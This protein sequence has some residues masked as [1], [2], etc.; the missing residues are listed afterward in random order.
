MLLVLAILGILFAV[1]LSTFAQ[2]SRQ[3]LVRQAAVQIQA[4]LEQLRSSAIRYNRNFE[5]RWSASDLNGYSID[6]NDPATAGNIINRDRV[7]PQ[8][9][10]LD[11]TG[12]AP[13]PAS[14]SIEYSSPLAVLEATPPV[15]RVRIAN[16][17]ITNPLF[18][19]IV[20]V[21]GR[22]AISATN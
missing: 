9:V 18:I 17:S 10:E 19:K 4:D 5:F 13:T 2:Q 7:L 14:I 11:V 6:A 22:V 21:T 1:G 12:L 16:S 3:A 20:G 8:G 15:L